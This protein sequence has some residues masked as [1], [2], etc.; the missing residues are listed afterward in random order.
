MCDH[1]YAVTSSARSLPEL[2]AA[3][4]DLEDDEARWEHARSHHG[5]LPPWSD[6]A[7]LGTSW[8]AVTTLSCPCCGGQAFERWLWHAEA[9]R[10]SVAAARLGKTSD[11]FWDVRLGQDHPTEH[12]DPP[13]H[14]SNDEYVCAACRETYIHFEELAPFGNGISS[15]PHCRAHA[16]GA[17][18]SRP[19]ALAAPADA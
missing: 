9:G 12:A 14:G 15:C 8:P 3:V 7:T 13:P 1:A 11:D 2:A 18:R 19:S 16:T 10:W 5:H 17:R 4:G 6:V